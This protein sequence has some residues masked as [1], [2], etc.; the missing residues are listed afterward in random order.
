MTSQPGKQ[1][2]KLRIL[3]NI[4]RI[5]V[6]QTVKFGQLIEHST[7]N[8]FLE[9]LYIKYGGGTSRKSKLS[10]SLYQQSEI[11]CSLLLLYVRVNGYWIIWKLRCRTLAFTS[12]NFK[13]RKEV[14]NQSRCLIFFCMIFEE[15]Y[16]SLWFSSKWPTKFRCLIAFT[17]RDIG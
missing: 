10:I 14:W 2:I 15:K 9:I 13:K 16:F 8:I 3:P 4:S 17:S 12:W 6:N 1:T 11:L 5:K 7:R